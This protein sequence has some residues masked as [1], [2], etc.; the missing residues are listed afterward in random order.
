[1]LKFK[2]KFWRQ[3]VNTGKLY[4]RHV[5]TADQQ[6]VNCVLLEE[7]WWKRRPRTPKKLSLWQYTI[8]YTGNIS[9]VNKS[10]KLLQTCMFLT[11]SCASSYKIT[12][13]YSLQCS[14]AVSYT[15]AGPKFS[16]PPP[17][18][19]WCRLARPQKQLAWPSCNLAHNQ[20][21]F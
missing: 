8:T 19:W 20:R 2:R 15:T 9:T 21:T 13:I 11:Q 4:Y 5:T 16:K 3:R 6:T 1:V 10:F 14:Q 7:M 17:W 18:L 12:I